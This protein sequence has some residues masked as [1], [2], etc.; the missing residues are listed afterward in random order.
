MQNG[1]SAILNRMFVVFG[2]A[3]LIPCAIG[4]QLIRINFFKGSELRELWSEQAIDY[5]PIPAQRG[6]IH[7]DDGS[8]LATNSVAYKVAIDPKVSG[9]SES[10][11]QQVCDT[12]ARYH[13]RSSGQYRQKINSAQQRYG[14]VVLGKNV[15]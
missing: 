6:N 2:L 8:L 4:M 5:I 14:Y 12:L 11:I 3:L 15:K 9:L 7:D 1:Q 10:Q 13:H